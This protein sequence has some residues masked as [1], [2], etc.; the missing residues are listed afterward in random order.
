MTDTHHRLQPDVRGHRPLSQARQPPAPTP[1]HP[2]S[3]G[4]GGSD[5]LAFSS[6]C[7]SSWE[8]GGLVLITSGWSGDG[9]REIKNSTEPPAVLTGLLRGEGGVRLA[10]AGPCWSLKFSQRDPWLHDGSPGELEKNLSV[11][12]T[13]QASSTHTRRGWSCASGLSVEIVFVAVKRTERETDHLT[14]LRARF[15][16]AHATDPP[17]HAQDFLISPDRKLSF[18]LVPSRCASAALGPSS[19]WTHTHCPSVSALFFLASCFQGSSTLCPVS[20]FPSL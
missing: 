4:T 3:A 19:K 1:P 20:E 13:P 12:T 14:I 2:T 16:V 10:K 15:A 9:A 8:S 17:I 11:Q 6:F 5:G 18:L 7:E